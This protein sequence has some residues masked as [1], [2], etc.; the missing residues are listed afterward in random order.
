MPTIPS[1]IKQS[2]VGKCGIVTMHSDNG[3]APIVITANNT[4]YTIISFSQ[5]EFEKLY[6]G[7]FFLLINSDEREEILSYILSRVEAKND[8]CLKVCINGKCGTTV[9]LLISGHGLGDG[10]IWLSFFEDS[11]NRDI[12]ELTGLYSISKFQRE[13]N[14]V[15]SFSNNEKF[16]ILSTD[17]EKFKI[18]NEHF[19]YEEGNRI[20]VSFASMLKKLLHLGEF[21]CR[22]YADRFLILIRCRDDV[23]LEKRFNEFIANLKTFQKS[24]KDGYSLSITTGVY[25]LLPGETDIISIIDKANIARKTAKGSHQNSIAIYNREIKSKIDQEADIEATMDYALS[26]HEFA[27][28]LQPKISLAT[29]RIIGAEALV[30]WIHPDGRIVNPSSFIPLFEKNG[31]IVTLDFYVYEAVLKTMAEWRER[32][33]PLIPIS[34]NVSPI[35]FLSPDFVTK[36]NELVDFYGIDHKLIELELTESTMINDMAHVSS[37]MRSFKSLGYVLSIDDFGSGYSSLNVLREIPADILKLDKDFFKDREVNQKSSTIVSYVIHMAK[38]L[39]LKVISEGVE[40]NSQKEFLKD[41][42]CDMAQGF[43]FSRPMPIC[44]FE[45]LL[46]IQNRQIA[47]VGSLNGAQ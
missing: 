12:D 44:D 22:Y 24:K 26:R 37:V 1:N 20:L 13:L 23:D 46:E 30:R 36:F 33:F 45:D 39:N 43:L 4:F 6:N 29:E 17:F 34:V 21:S 42:N 5:S 10:K 27:V 16:M 9:P 32:C 47:A 18:T 11:F 3:E 15:I 38:E 8:F 41:N 28:F 19:G 2:F 40:T 25:Y 31:F 35:H 7:N 14:K